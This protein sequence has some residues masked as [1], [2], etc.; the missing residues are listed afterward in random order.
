MVDYLAFVLYV[1][2]ISAW[3]DVA[4][5]GDENVIKEG[6]ERISW[7]FKMGPIGC[8][9]TSVR[10]CYDMLRNNLEQPAYETHP[11]LHDRLP[12]HNQPKKQFT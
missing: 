4:I 9:E 12:H 6:A 7:P 1:P 3:L 11:T 10:K 8:P 2:P 5:S